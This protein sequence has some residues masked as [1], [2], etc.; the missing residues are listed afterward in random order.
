MNNLTESEKWTLIRKLEKKPLPKDTIQ[1]RWERLN[2]LAQLGRE[3]DLH[4]DHSE[5]MIVYERWARIKDAYEERLRD[6]KP[7]EK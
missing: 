3:L 7:E 2:E 4:I 6:K 1:T 5:K